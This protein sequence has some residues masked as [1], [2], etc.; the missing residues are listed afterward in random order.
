MAGEPAGPGAPPP[1]APGSKNAKPSAIS[2]S[3]QLPP[4]LTTTATGNKIYLAAGSPPTAVVGTKSPSSPSAFPSLAATLTAGAT[5][6]RVGVTGNNSSSSSSSMYGYPPPP[7]SPPPQQGGSAGGDDGA[8]TG[9]PLSPASSLWSPTRTYGGTTGGGGAYAPSSSSSSSS[10]PPAS[11]SLPVDALLRTAA[12]FPQASLKLAADK[13]MKQLQA[14]QVAG[15]DVGIHSLCA[16]ELL[17]PPEAEI[18]YF[19]LPFFAKPPTCQLLFSSKYV[20]LSIFSHYYYIY[21]NILFFYY[22]IC[23]TK[24]SMGSTWIAC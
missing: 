23:T 8:M 1:I 10:Q 24:G 9:S 16:S 6:N 15:C 11:F 19:S 14:R 20:Y 2:G 18:V 3:P 12:R 13:K 22:L 7:S 4:K 21:F 5:M 17:T